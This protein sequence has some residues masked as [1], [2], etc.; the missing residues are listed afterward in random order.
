MAFGIPN[1]V[2]IICFLLVKLFLHPLDCLN[3]ANFALAL[4]FVLEKLLFYP[5]NCSTW[6]FVWHWDWLGA[7]MFF[8]SFCWDFLYFDSRG[9]FNSL[10]SHFFWIWGQLYNA[11]WYIGTE[12][13]TETFSSSWRHSH[14]SWGNSLEPLLLSVIW[15]LYDAFGSVCVQRFF[16]RHLTFFWAETIWFHENQPNAWRWRG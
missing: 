14:H 8:S 13:C 11:V 12:R 2:F 6:S 9:K 15:N 3:F 1:C 4:D 16:S 7:L 10:I 5:W